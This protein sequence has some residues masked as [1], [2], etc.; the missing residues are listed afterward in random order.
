[1]LIAT[2]SMVKMM[3]YII[4]FNAVGTLA[5]IVQKLAVLKLKANSQVDY[6]VFITEIGSVICGFMLNQML[7]AP[8]E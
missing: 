6:L 7:S 4:M 3:A 5:T 2:F 8:D 1:M